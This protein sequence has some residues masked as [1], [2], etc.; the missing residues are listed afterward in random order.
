MYVMFKHSQQ[1]LQCVYFP[2]TGILLVVHDFVNFQKE[3]LRGE[4][5]IN[6][7]VSCSTYTSLPKES[8]CPDAVDIINVLV[9]A[10]ENCQ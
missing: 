9:L 8:F 3:E 2:R 10:S 7:I 1:I 4:R 6:Y 5:K